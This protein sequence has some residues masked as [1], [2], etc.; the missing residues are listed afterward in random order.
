MNKTKY[1]IY[2]D[3]SFK[4]FD[5]TQAHSEQRQ[6]SNN[7]ISAA[8]INIYV[9]KNQPG[10]VLVDCY[11]ESISLRMKARPEDN[12]IIAKGLGLYDPWSDEPLKFY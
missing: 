8:F 3:G 4:L 5:E 2:D 1:V 12:K 6:S 9:A 7:I 10:R 11:G